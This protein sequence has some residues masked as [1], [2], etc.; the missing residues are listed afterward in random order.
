MQPMRLKDQHCQPNQCMSVYTATQPRVYA[1][2]HAATAAE[3]SAQ[4]VDVTVQCLSTAMQ[5]KISITFIK[6]PGN[7][8]LPSSADCAL[9]ALSSMIKNK[10]FVLIP[11]VRRSV[12]F[13]RFIKVED[14]VPGP[15]F[16]PGTLR[17][18]LSGTFLQPLPELVTSLKGHSLS[19]HSCPPML[20]AHSKMFGH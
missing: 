12:R 3:R 4:A 19:P 9:H 10:L 6:H 16:I 5:W 15:V 7:V 8:F 20:S 11:R 14:K 18:S 13:I 17:A 1:Y 2:T